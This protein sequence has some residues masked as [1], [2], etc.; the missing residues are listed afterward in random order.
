MDQIAKSQEKLALRSELDDLKVR[1]EG[2][3]DDIRRLEQRIDT[4]AS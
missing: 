4:S 3:R 1:V 2:L